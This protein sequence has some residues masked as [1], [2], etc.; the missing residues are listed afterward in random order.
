M[1]KINFNYLENYSQSISEKFCSKYFETK[2]YMSGQEIIQLTPS[3]QVNLLVI[4]A[5]F[6]AWQDELEKLKSN[7]YFDYRDIAVDNSLK[8]FM[9]ILSRAIKVERVHFEPLM[10]EAVEDALLLA[11]DPVTFFIHLIE[12]SKGDRNYFKDTK[13]YIKWHTDLMGTLMDKSS[14]GASSSELKMALRAKYENEKNKMERYD[15]LL[16]PL[17]QVQKIDYTKLVEQNDTGSIQEERKTNALDAQETPPVESA[18]KFATDSTDSSSSTHNQH[19]AA[20]SEKA[21]D[22]ALA[23]AR[24]ESEEYSIIKG[25]IGNLSESVGIN[26]RFMFTRELFQGN[27]DLMKHAL[28]SIDR[29]DSFVEA[30]ELINQRYVEELDWNKNSDEVNEFLQLVFRKF[31]QK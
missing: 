27:A 24:F 15:R 30:V 1:N 18:E 29:C 10:R 14:M 9:N 23:W 8:E 3:Q 25:S 16:E 5:L 21:I 28:Q 19:K 4:K 31:E 20:S 22:P 26:Q 6:S 11:I 12:E 2:K 17:H 13:K 7:P